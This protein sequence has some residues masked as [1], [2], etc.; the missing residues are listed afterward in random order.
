MPAKR[1]YNCQY[2][3][4]VNKSFTHQPFANVIV[5]LFLSS[6]YHTFRFKIVNEKQYL[7]IK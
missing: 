5:L 7:E 1:C 2:S 6:S 4:F 3:T